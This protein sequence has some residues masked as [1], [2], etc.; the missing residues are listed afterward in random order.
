MFIMN[1]LD[2][3]TQAAVVRCLVDGNSIRAASR[4]VGVSSNTITKLLV[5]LGTACREHHDR[6]VRGVTTQRVQC[7]EIWSFVYGKDKNLSA[8]QKAD[9]DKGSMWTWTAIDADS[10]L[11]ISYL[12]GARDAGYAW[13]FMQDVKARLANRVQ[14][15][16]DGHKPYLSAV[17]DAFGDDVDYAML[18]K[19]FG[20]ED[21]GAGRY[22]PPKCTGTV[23]KPIMGSPEAEHVSTSYVER[24]NLTMRMAMRRFTRLTNAFSKKLANLE[25]AVS[26]HFAYYKFLPRSQDAACH[27]GDGSGADGPRVVD[28][29]FA[30]ALAAAGRCGVGIQDRQEDRCLAGLRRKATGP[31]TVSA[32][33]RRPTD[34]GSRRERRGSNARGRVDTRTLKHAFRNG[35]PA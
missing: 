30:R 28:R 14:L 23:R 16:T 19:E 17:A 4:I 9:G 25:H 7:D 21:A 20:A 5:D 10:K 24:Q 34:A 1:R 29:G 11:V 26:L 8:E 35:I 33:V 12:I 13:E 2:T 6:T 22:S 32:H 3:S 27:S 18:I 15:T 31:G